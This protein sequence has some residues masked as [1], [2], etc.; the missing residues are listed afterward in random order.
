MAKTIP[1]HGTENRYTNHRCRC[2]QC[3]TAAAKARAE[4]KRRAAYAQW[5]GQHAMV[6]AEPVRRHIVILR[7]AGLSV[8]KVAETAGVGYSVVRHVLYGTHGLPPASQVFRNNAEAILR[9]PLD[10]EVMP[11]CARVDGAGTRRR[12]QA[13]IALGWTSQEI[14]DRVGYTRTYVTAL[15]RRAQVTAEAAH[16]ILKVYSELSMRVPPDTHAARMAKAFAK[17]KGWI[18][19]LAWDD[20]L[21]DLSDEDLAAELRRQV[22]L[23]SYT[24]LAAAHN[25]R[26][27][28]GDKTPLTLEASRE[29]KRRQKARSE[30]GEAS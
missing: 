8:A 29:Y 27:R 14:A 21:I 18:P 26:H 12:V 11:S 30:L 25:A 5:T 7:Q 3:R 28:H 4:R 17:R 15:T 16:R 19:P 23:W 22:E 1:P 10:V 2:G 9:V 13:L 20:D 24:E 6:D